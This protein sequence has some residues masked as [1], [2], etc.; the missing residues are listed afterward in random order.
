M[1][2]YLASQS[3]L[4][5]EDVTIPTL[6]GRAGAAAARPAAPAGAQAD[7]VAA[8]AALPADLKPD[9]LRSQVLALL[10]HASAS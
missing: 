8:L 10:R 7:L 6:P 3:V 5:D 4:D 9:V 2:T 1:A